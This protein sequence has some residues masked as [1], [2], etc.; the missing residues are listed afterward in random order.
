MATPFKLERL[1][2]IREARQEIFPS[3]SERWIKEQIK[4]GKFGDVIRD[5]GGWLIPQSGILVYLERNRVQACAA[6]PVRRE[7]LGNLV[8]NQ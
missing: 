8:Q 7:Q 5:A 3:R 6:T 1:L 2:S 4:A